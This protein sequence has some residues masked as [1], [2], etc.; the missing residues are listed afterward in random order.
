MGIKLIKYAQDAEH[1]TG[2]YEQGKTH[3][4][5]LKYFVSVP[6]RVT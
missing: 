3:P 5:D 2:Q 6:E 1:P 4:L